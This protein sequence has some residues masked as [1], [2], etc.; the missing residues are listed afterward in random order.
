MLTNIWHKQR[1]LK[2]WLLNEGI[3][4][5]FFFMFHIKNNI[6]INKVYDMIGK[7]MVRD[8]IFDLSIGRGQFLYWIL[9]F[10]EIN[11]CHSVEDIR[12][13]PKINIKNTINN[14]L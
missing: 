7:P 14:L 5:M 10:W 9:T 4:L 12:F 13:H 6:N 11:P 3:T 8:S 2:S 1:N